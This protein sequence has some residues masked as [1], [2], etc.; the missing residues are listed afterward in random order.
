MS[1]LD[2]CYYVP[3]NQVDKIELYPNYI[4]ERRIY[5]GQA[6]GLVTEEM[7]SFLP[8]GIYTTSTTPTERNGIVGFN[9][10]IGRWSTH[11]DSLILGEYTGILVNYMTEPLDEKQTINSTPITNLRELSDAPPQ[12]GDADN[13]SRGTIR[14]F[15]DEIVFVDRDGK[16][17]I[18]YY[19]PSGL[20]YYK[21]FWEER[22]Y[23]PLAVMVREKSTRISNA[24][25][26]KKT[27]YYPWMPVELIWQS[28]EYKTFRKQYGL[29][30]EPLMII[31]FKDGLRFTVVNP[32]YYL[33]GSGL[34]LYD[35]ADEEALSAWMDT[36]Q[37]GRSY[38]FELIR[39]AYPADSIAHFP[40]LQTVPDSIYAAD[41]EAYGYFFARI[42]S[43]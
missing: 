24:R 27:P 19:L 39:P 12:D 10:G 41:G 32:R 5:Y 16:Q 36:V 38:E 9:N 29:N 31:L 6:A 25:Q 7:M 37:V 23:E 8:S 26:S 43:R 34:R 2:R 21:D 30:G 11:G 35:K 33:P 15:G 4:G 42:K 28:G 1:F 40:P 22:Y 3:E 13:V 20:I 17:R 18:F 14:H